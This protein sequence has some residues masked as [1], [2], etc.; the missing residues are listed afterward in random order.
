[1]KRNNILVTGASGFVG[2]FLLERLIQTDCNMI[3]ALHNKSL[4]KSIRERCGDKII[5]KNTNLVSDDCC[6]LLTDIDIVFHLAGYSSVFSSKE[7]IDLLQRVNVGV[8][9][10]LAEECL[11]SP[12]RQFIF[13]S[14]ISVCECSVSEVIDETNG[15]PVTPY[16]DSKKKAEDTLIEI[17]DGHYAVTILRPTSLFGEYHKGSIYELVQS[18]KFHRFVIFGSGNN[19]TNFYYIRDFIELLINVKDN[20]RAFNQV[21][22]ASDNAF[23]LVTLIEWIVESLKCRSYIL[24]VPVWIGYIAGFILDVIAY[25]TNKTFPFSLR[26]LRAMTRD[27]VYLNR[28]SINTLNVKPKYGVHQ[29]IINTIEW[30]DNNGLL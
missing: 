3:V 5:W 20:N 21:F 11:T 25:L 8:T 28:K 18:V 30:Y 23:Q 4:K 2:Q 15:T 26:R 13:V 22:I 14:S 17:A 19:M 10:K 29:G 1:M 7:E 9:K 27:V 16:G 6:G 24:K 12:V